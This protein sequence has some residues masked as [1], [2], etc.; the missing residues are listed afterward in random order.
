MSAALLALAVTFAAS[1]HC[2]GMCG[3][4]AVAV[5]AGASR[6]GLLARQLLLHLGKATTYAFLGAL[7]GAFGGA[8]VSSPSLRGGGRLLAVAAGLAALGAGLTLL[9]VGSGGGALSRRIAPVWS[10]LFGPLLAARPAGFPLVV[11]M[12]IGLLPCPL[13]YAGLGAAA[14]TGGAARGALV[15]AAVALGTVPALLVVAF[16]GSAFAAV[17]RRPLARIAGAILLATGIL[18]LVRAVRPGACHPAASAAAAECCE[19]AR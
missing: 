2:M 3:G 16:A 8:V 9:G 6:A 19:S 17:W 7:A 4:F 14:A 5:S 1:V 13:V 15:M 18:T 12:A 10:R 11:G